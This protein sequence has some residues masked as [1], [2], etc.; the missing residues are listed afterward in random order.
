MTAVPFISSVHLTMLRAHPVT[1]I[2]QKSQQDILES[3]C[4]TEITLR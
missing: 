3:A 2:W 4:K 1:Q